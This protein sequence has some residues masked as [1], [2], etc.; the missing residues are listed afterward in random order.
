MVILINFNGDFNFY[1]Y[2]C[3]FLFILSGLS[4]DLKKEK[5]ETERLENEKK[6]WLSRGISAEFEKK[7]KVN[8]L[9]FSLTLF[10]GSFV[11]L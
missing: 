5:N 8:N 11:I 1:Y 2:Q 9:I 3:N 4:E 6:D 10:K 7:E